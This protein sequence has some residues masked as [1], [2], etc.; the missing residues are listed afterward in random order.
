MT[1]W[2]SRYQTGDTPWEKGQAAPPLVEVLE[3]LEAD[4]WGCG[5]I[6]VPGC[7]F[8]HDVR[9]LAGM[10][11]PVTGVDISESAVE[12]ARRYAPVGKETYELGD[13]LDPAWLGGRCFSAI[14]EHTCFCAI[15]PAE[16]GRYA[17]SAAAAA[18]LPDGGLLAG[19]FFINPF[20]PGED[21]T[22]PPFGATVGELDNWFAPW[23]DRVEGWVPYSSF[24]GREEREWVALFRKRPQA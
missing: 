4:E 15:N 1:D 7:G 5:P 23:F 10:G 18:A 14:W 19:V 22:G 2:E 8:G 16:R 24:A 12:T 9:L 20:D 3:E 6:L 11:L 21:A 17:R 13:F